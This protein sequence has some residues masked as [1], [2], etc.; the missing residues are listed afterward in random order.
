ME[1]EKVVPLPHQQGIHKQKGKERTSSRS[2]R[3]SRIRSSR[4]SRRHDHHDAP[5]AEPQAEKQ[6]QKKEAG[7]KTD[8]STRI[9]RTHSAVS[10]ASEEES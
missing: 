5:N 3:S 7:G 1:R 4:R 10:E 8:E 9:Q 6:K 2:S